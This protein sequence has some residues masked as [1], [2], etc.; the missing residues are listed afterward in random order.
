MNP[1]SRRGLAAALVGAVLI[2]LLASCGLSAPYDRGPYLRGLE[3][4]CERV[5]THLVAQGVNARC[6]EDAWAIIENDGVAYTFDDEGMRRIENDAA[7]IAV[8]ATAFH[9][10]VTVI[11]VMVG[12]GYDAP[13][14]KYDMRNLS[15]P[16]AFYHLDDLEWVQR[17]IEASISTEEMKALVEQAERYQGLIKTELDNVESVSR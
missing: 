13:K 8:L 2:S 17:T 11:S 9:T 7:L 4:H 12:D 15:S 1:T 5:T 6:D 10:K 14:A 16:R 3:R